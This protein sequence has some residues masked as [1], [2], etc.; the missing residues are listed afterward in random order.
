[1]FHCRDGVVLKRVRY[2]R[3][4]STLFVRRS[5]GRRGD[6]RPFVDQ[7]GAAE[8]IDKS[9][10]Q[11]VDAFADRQLDAIL[12]GRLRIEEPVVPDED[13]SS[14]RRRRAS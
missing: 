1:M 6:K 14:A 8:G 4:P 3:T 12:D 5:T 11:G 7:A 9:T 2:T 10:G 13:V